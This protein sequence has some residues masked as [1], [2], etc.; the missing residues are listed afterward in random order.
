MYDYG[1]YHV[2]ITRFNGRSR[3]PRR[4]P[5]DYLILCTDTYNKLQKYS[6]TYMIMVYIV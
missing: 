4:E 6:N 5:V 1:I 2:V 3:G